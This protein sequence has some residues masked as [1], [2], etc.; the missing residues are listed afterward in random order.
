MAWTKATLSSDIQNAASEGNHLLLS[1]NRL[2]EATTIEWHSGDITVS[3]VEVDRLDAS[4]PAYNLYDG[5]L[6][7]TCRPSD[8]T[9]ATYYLYAE[10][11]SVTLDCIFL[12]LGSLGT[13]AATATIVFE[14]ADSF[15][16]DTNR[17]AI[18]THTLVPTE[19]TVMALN[20]DDDLGNNYQRFDKVDQLR[21]TITNGAGNYVPQ[22][23]Q[24]SFGV[25]RQLTGRMDTGW[26][27]SP[28]VSSFVESHGPNHH[29]GRLTNQVNLRNYRG[30][31]LS[32]SSPTRFSTLNDAS[33]IQGAYQECGL[34]SKAV[35][36]VEDP[37]TAGTSY[38][39]GAVMGHMTPGLKLPSSGYATRQWSFG[40][41]EQPVTEAT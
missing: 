3:G 10:L 28:S 35:V 17:I 5:R 26:D 6:S 40:F 12:R 25:R 36:F 32:N 2:S 20:L 7:T 18:S 33:T 21:V 41:Y 4:Y 38:P 22:I 1:R 14:I 15:S 29:I 31:Y 16:S 39:H 11:P 37:S 30:S 34:G 27:S 13:S 19:S 9:V 23:R 8:Q 24:L